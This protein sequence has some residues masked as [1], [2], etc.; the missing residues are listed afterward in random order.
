VR[1]ADLIAFPCPPRGD[2][3]TGTEH[4]IDGGTVPKNEIAV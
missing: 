2:A 4:I 1:W 3:I